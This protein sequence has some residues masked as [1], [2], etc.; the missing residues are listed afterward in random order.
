MLCVESACPR[1]RRLKIFISYRRKESS[2]YSGRIYDRLREALPE[3]DVFM[4]V[5]EIPLG[6]RWR[7]VLDRRLRAAEV[8]LVLI[9]DEWR[10]L[11]DD[12]GR[13]R[14]DD[15]EDVTRWE[16]ETALAL[17]KRLVPVLLDHTPPLA[18]EELP[19][20]LAPLAELQAVRIRHEAFEAG[21]EDLI[22]RLTGKRLRDEVRRAR[23]RL[24]LE[25]AKRWG[26]PA[27]ALAIVLLAWTRFFDV[28]TLDTRFATWTLALADAL[29]PPTLDPSLVL[30]AIGAEQP[31]ADADMRERYA[32]LISALA[33]AGSRRAVLDLYFHV[34]KASDA[35][36]ARAMTQA[37][38]SGMQ[39]FF[40]F[41]ETENGKPRAV[42]DLAQAAS[43]TG[44]ACAGRRLGYALS[45]PIAFDIVREAD[46]WRVSPLP[47]LAL[48]GAAGD[49]R[50]EGI[51]P[52]SR[53]I[54]LRN[55]SVSRRQPFSMLGNEI[56]GKQACAAIVTG[57]R[58][59]ELVVRISPLERLRER[60]VT[61]DDVLAG[62]VGAERLAGK[63]VVIGY[64]TPQETFPVAHG[65]ARETR[66]GYELQA[67]ALNSL[68]TGRVMRFA[69]AG[70]QTAMAALFAALGAWLGAR[71]CRWGRSYACLPAA[72]VVA[73]YIALAVAVAAAEDLLL[74][75]AY[76]IGAFVFAYVLFRVLA[77]RW[78]T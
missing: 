5:E 12:S 22:G 54:D 43:A 16:L 45:I 64:E 34:P 68:A 57:T 36:L 33:R 46:R 23:A 44:L 67:D 41:I 3:A 21:L 2:G 48:L 15:P 37:R 1:S 39:V 18:P 71:V 19:P 42:A 56:R 14:L 35:V 11:Q 72:A 27:I 13:R 49:V 30:V 53:S 24:L 59:A 51:D 17:R 7:D 50:I 9:G 74:M 8:V 52:R 66:F 47:A 77:R 62:R 73:A 4:D 38:E 65:L 20:T 26:V 63:T 6:E 31:G 10:T 29:A 58:V 32:A 76:D 25:R 61:F 70:V 55:A 40:G 60:R 78:T 69:G 75:S 28:F